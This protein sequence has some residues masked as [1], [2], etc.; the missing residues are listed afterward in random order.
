MN[1]QLDLVVPGDHHLEVTLDAFCCAT[2]GRS[3]AT[4]SI[5]AATKI[6]AAATPRLAEID[7]VVPIARAGLAMLSS[8][9]LAT[10]YL[11][12]LFAICRRGKVGVSCTWTPPA[13]VTNARHPAVLD[14]VAATGRTVELVIG[15]LHE[16]LADLRSITVLV[17]F[18]TPDA[19]DA[20]TAATRVPTCV[21]IGRLC[22]G[23]DSEGYIIPATHG[24]AGDK[25]FGAL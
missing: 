25:L 23:V 1:S 8:V 15:S 13:L 12:T 10:G 14:V 22:D 19:L 20:L 3:Q 5:A 9:D 24:D 7:L 21:V 2:A 17:C 4:A 16:R 11:D 6:I 18:A